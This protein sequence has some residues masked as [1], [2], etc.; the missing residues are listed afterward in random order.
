MAQEF[1]FPEVR[2]QLEKIARQFDYLAERS[3]RR[4]RPVPIDPAVAGDK[5][6]PGK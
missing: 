3:E 4:Q 6:K 1:R 2:D 5:P